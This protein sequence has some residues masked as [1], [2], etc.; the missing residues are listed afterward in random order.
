MNITKSKVGFMKGGNL[1]TLLQ[2]DENSKIKFYY[3]NGFINVATKDE[4]LA[5]LQGI[6][7]KDEVKI[8]YYLNGTCVQLAVSEDI[9]YD[10]VYTLEFNDQEGFENTTNVQRDS[11]FTTIS[12][13]NVEKKVETIDYNN[14]N[15]ELT[16]DS[17]CTAHTYH[18]DLSVRIA[19]ILQTSIDY[20]AETELAY[21][22]T[23]QDNQ[24]GSE[25]VSIELDIAQGNL[26]LIEGNE[27]N[28]TLNNTV[29]GESATIITYT[30][31]E[32]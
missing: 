22:K 16:Y 28:F 3:D 7:Y 20:T 15:A 11:N 10:N 6:S 1:Y 23:I 17:T 31:D 32:V 25:L 29:I 9:V 27:V 18:I 21:N 26:E 14:T 5:N 8:Y 13:L 30:E 4:V 12:P 24:N 2:K 19:N